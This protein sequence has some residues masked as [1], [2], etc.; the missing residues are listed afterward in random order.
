MAII[1]GTNGDDNALGIATA[2]SGNDTYNALDGRD[3]LFP[4][5]GNDTLNGGAGQDAAI[6]DS[7]SQLLTNGITINNTTAAIG[8]VAAQTTDKRGFG[9]DVLIAM[10]SFHGTNFNDKI[11]LGK[12]EDGSYTIDRAG[13]DLVV[14]F[15]GA[16]TESNYFVA[17]PGND[18]YVGGQADGDQIDYGNTDI[19]QTQ[20]VNVVY[21]S[22]GAGTATDSWGDTDTFSGIE[23]ITGTAFADRIFMGAENRSDVTGGAGNDT[24]DGGAGSRDRLRY[25]REA[26]RGGFQ[27][28]VVDL[29]AATATDSFGNTDTISNFEEVNGTSFADTLRGNAGDNK[30]AG[31]GGADLLEGRGGEGRFTGGAGN[32]TITGGSDYDEAR[33]DSEDGIQGANV[34]LATGTATDEFGNTDT[35][36]SIEGVV[37]TD[38]NDTL[39]GNDASNYFEGRGG[40]DL[41]EGF[42]ESDFF[43]CG[44]GNDTMDGGEGGA[45]D[46][47]R[48]QYGSDADDTAGQNGVIIDLAA[49]TATDG[50]GDTDTLIGIENA[51]G[52][53]FADVMRGSADSNDFAGER[54]DDLLVGFE[55][56]D[57][58]RGGAGKD[59]MDGGDG[60]IN[61]FDRVE[62]DRDAEDAAGQSGVIVDLVAGTATDGYGDTDTLIGIENVTGTRFGDRIIGDDGE[63]DLNG[64]DGDDTLTGGAGGDFLQPGAGNDSID[65]GANGVLGQKDALSYQYDT[66]ATSGITVTFTA[67]NAGIV[68]D[69]S[70]GTDTFT[71][72]EY[73][74][75]THFADTFIGTDG[76]QSIRANGGN[77][78]IDGGAGVDDELDYFDSGGGDEIAHG[79]VVVDMVAGTASD[80]FGGTDTFTNIENIRGSEFNDNILGNDGNNNLRGDAGNDTIDGGLGDNHLDG[81]Q[82]NDIIISRSRQDGIEGGAGDDTITIY[83]GDDDDRPYVDPGLGSNTIVQ[84]GGAEIQLSYRSLDQGV[85]I[86][87]ALGQTIKQGG[88]VDTFG[89]VHQVSGS[90]GNDTIF[91]TDR[92]Y[93][94]YEATFGSDTIDGRGGFDELRF[95]ND[96]ETGVTV[97]MVAG[98]ATGAFSTLVTFSNIESIQGSRGADSV[99]GSGADYEQFR[100]LGG[101]DT[102]DGRGGYDEVSYNSDQYFGGDGVGV[103]VN[104]AAGTATDALG[105]T[106]TLISVEG[107]S[108]T[109]WDDRLDGSSEVNWLNGNAG[110]DSLNGHEGDDF[111]IGG[112]GLDTVTGGTGSDVYRGQINDLNGDT[113]TDFAAGERIWVVDENGD[114]VGANITTDGTSIFIDTTGD[115]VAEAVMINGNGFVGPIASYGGPVGGTPQ[116]AARITLDGNASFSATVTEGNTGTN[117]VTATIR[118]AGDLASS[119]TVNYLVAGFG[120]AAADSADLASG[121]GAGSVTFAA[122]QTEAQVTLQV[123][124]DLS[125]EATEALSLTLTGAVGTGVLPVE[126]AASETYIR[127]LNDDFLSR[128]SI[129]GQKVQE[130][131]GH[132]TF[133]VTRDGADLSQALTASYSLT[134]GDGLRG[135]DPDDVVGGLPQTGTVSFAAGQST[136]TISLGIF[137]DQVSEFHEIVVA[138]ITGLGG[139]GAATHEIGTAQAVGEIRNDDGIPPLTGIGFIPPASSYADPH[140]ITFDG[141]AYDFQAVGE[142][143]L[144]EAVSGDPLTVQVRYSAVPGSDLASQTTAVSTDLGG[145]QVAFDIAAASALTVDGVAVDL[146]SAAGGLDVG[147]GQVFF[148]GEALT[149]VYASGE[150]MRVDVFDGFLNVSLSVLEGHAMRGLLGSNDGNSANDLA[151]RDG[152]VLAQP[153]TFADLYG[154]YADDWRLS[155]ATSLFDY[156]AG[157]GTA[158]FTNLDFPA[159]VLSLSDIPAALLDIAEAAAA[160][161]SDPIL[162][163]AAIHD[164]LLSGNPDYIAAAEA[165]T[166]APTAQTA[167]IDAPEID[168]AIGV[169]ASDSRIV[170]GDDGAT[171][172]VYTVY[173][174]GDLADPTTLTYQINGAVI[175]YGNGNLSFA[176]GE[177]VTS[178]SIDITGDSI[179]EADDQI[180][181][182]FQTVAPGALILNS[183]VVTDLIDDDTGPIAKADSFATGEDNPLSGNVLQD[184]GGGAD[185]GDGTLTVTALIA[186]NGTELAVGQTHS[187]DFGTVKL[188]ADGSFVYDPRGNAF[189]DLDT[190]ETA[191]VGFGYLV[192]DGV[193]KSAGMVDITVT[194]ADEKPVFNE[195][196]GTQRHD[197][198]R[199]TAGNDI[200]RSL[201]GSDV[202]NGKGGE[203]WFVF[204]D[205]THNCRREVDVIRRFNWHEDAIVLDADTEIRSIRDVGRGVKITFEGDHDSVLVYGRGVDHDNIRILQSDALENWV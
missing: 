20:G 188:N 120:A 119:V 36:T 131:S 171:T 153:V 5:A 160:G 32:D 31:F 110:A 82:G 191:L 139:L 48:V 26:E 201:G 108:G 113:I 65:G 2:T 29:A 202:M 44:A 17:G 38:F 6:Y 16:T 41:M 199:G 75:G 144:V 124:G 158:N 165:L 175:V 21:T 86:D 115:G 111:L 45:D 28:V 176:A 159:G 100:M 73:V 85:Q 34:N 183:R 81:G 204:G 117:A 197:F 112:A 203:D 24:L 56:N 148:D 169:F 50:Y 15:Q 33:Y 80:G 67:E 52:T 98:T 1:T 53:Q 143:T 147:N 134:G 114:D 23:R 118:R 174:I 178:V 125:R 105:D 102:I 141:L 135:A 46:E 103:T 57:N 25:D 95:T 66:D 205:E 192:S 93:E 84:L 4:S 170:E 76:R 97:D 187:F 11:Y 12:T 42:G 22:A 200:I 74:R 193:N 13:D 138:Q 172:L 129:S 127:V 116:V 68:N 90:F 60:G 77:D 181:F 122:G 198:I 152:T 142:F 157:Q 94:A 43:R 173:R 180:V 30:L 19:P 184:N 166:A 146:A 79:P 179:V 195:I 91:G 149:V 8:S 78:T 71:G 88:A 185:T 182:Q 161:I 121:F 27:G 39:R 104:L 63:N 151:L 194:G 128:V 109:A 83:Q 133:T 126:L 189:D 196:T 61:D 89:I 70:G 59:T 14:A 130:D 155:D 164:F 64:G 167:I 54:G 58:F 69:W 140:L 87:L 55:R 156:P 40:N 177:A 162:R 72:I 101:D 163:D 7:S 190:G 150:Q 10:E 37:G 96:Q 154:V 9:T 168:K 107:A 99:N 49:G 51:S 132:L 145:V 92:E 35:L 106:D 123:Q 47:D 18:T 186:P 3:F 136:A 62:Y 137:A